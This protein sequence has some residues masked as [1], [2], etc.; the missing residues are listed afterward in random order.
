M[1][2]SINQSMFDQFTYLILSFLIICKYY[3]GLKTILHDD[4]RWLDVNER[5]EY[6]LGV[7]VYQC[8]HDQAPRYLADH[9]ITASDAAPHRLR[10][11]SAHLNRLTFPRCRLSTYTAVGLF[12]TL[13]PTVWNSMQLRH[14]DCFDEFKP[15][16]TSIHFCR[17]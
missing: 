2:E 6:K 8:L 5:I 10:L 9:L 11:R 1:N 4:L 12:I 13:A 7:M 17:C 14:Y 16:L 3:R 15:F